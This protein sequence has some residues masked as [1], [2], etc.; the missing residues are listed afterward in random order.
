MRP[1]V[2]KPIWA[3]VWPDGRVL[4]DSTFKDE[5]HAWMIALGWPDNQEIEL[6][7]SQGYKAVQI[8]I[9]IVT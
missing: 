7:K 2:N 3:I 5:A 9:Q 1:H 6:A 8:T 4:A